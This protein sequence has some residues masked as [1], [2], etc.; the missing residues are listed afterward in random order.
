MRLLSS[1]PGHKRETCSLIGIETGVAT[2]RIELSQAEHQKLPT[3]A[4]A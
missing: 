3:V 4:G 1:A 2:A